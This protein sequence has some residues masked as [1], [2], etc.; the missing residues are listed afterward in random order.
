M[1]NV[2]FL[3]EP[4]YLYDLFFLFVLRFNKDFCLTN[5]I[6]YGQSSQDTEYFN[7]VLLDYDDI[8][9]ELLPFFSLKDNGKC[10]M[11]ELYYEPY[12]EEFTAAYNLA[13]VQTAL[14]NHERLYPI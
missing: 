10:F 14:M 4:G 2:K 1:K 5:M 13:M 11:T 9:D 6:N 8:S 12:T 7:R 3:K